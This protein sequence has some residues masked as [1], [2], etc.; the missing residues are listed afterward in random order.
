M[1][2]HKDTDPIRQIFQ[3]VNLQNRYFNPDFEHELV[4]KDLT[5]DQAWI[6]KKDLDNNTPPHLHHV[7]LFTIVLPGNSLYVKEEINV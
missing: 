2:R 7:V 3:I 6:L 4:A 5:K 1:A